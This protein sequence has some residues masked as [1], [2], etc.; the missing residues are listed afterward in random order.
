MIDMAVD[1]AKASFSMAA[2]DSN[3]RY[4]TPPEDCVCDG[5]G[6]DLLLGRLRQLG[7]PGEVRVGC[8]ATGHYWLLLAATVEDAGYTVHAFNPILTGAPTRTT[9]RGRKSDHDDLAQIARVM[10]EG[11]YSPVMLAAGDL[12]EL[13]QLC[14]HRQRLVDDACNLKKRLTGYLDLVFPEWGRTVKEAHGATALAILAMAPSARLIAALKPEDLLAMVRKASHGRHGEAF[15][16]TL[17]T[18]AKGSLAHRR[19]SLACEQAIRNL[20]ELIGVMQRQIDALDQQIQALAPQEDLHRLMTIPGVGGI[21]AALILAEILSISR[22]TGPDPRRDQ[23]TKCRGSNGFH[24]FLAFAGLDARIRESGEYQGKN[25][26]SKRG[27]RLLRTAIWRAAYVA[28]NHEAFR[29]TWI[30]HREVLKQPMKLAISHVARKLAQ[31]IYG[32]L[33]HRTDFDLAAFRGKAA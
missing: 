26:M 10:R 13:Q 23:R 15:V 30:H 25:K 4:K 16:E 8:E 20:V 17:L 2:F 6:L 7:P 24:R 32:V 27:S 18:M 28:R 19:P 9:V 1:I 22:F 12:A 11:R 21:L 29:D 33:S 31:A 5:P 3:G 14:R